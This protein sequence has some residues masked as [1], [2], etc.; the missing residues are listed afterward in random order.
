MT[1]QLA[2][3]CARVCC[4]LLAGLLMSACA[5]SAPGA[6]GAQDKTEFTAEVLAQS[7]AWHDRRISNY[8]ITYLLIEDV[9]S[10]APA[11]RQVKVRSG[12]VLDT[13]CPESI[14]PTAQLRDLRLVPE[15][16][17]MIRDNS[18]ECEFQIIY[19]KD[20]HFPSVIDR[21]CAKL[22]V[23]DRIMVTSFAPFPP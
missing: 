19:N 16:F 4:V 10:G 1:C 12:A 3:V 11:Y 23:H 5:L 14:C 7:E 22:G 20:F 21:T 2:V 17:T 9:A 6:G 18:A 8:N 15:L 13:I